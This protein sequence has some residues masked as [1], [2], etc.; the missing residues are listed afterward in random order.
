[1]AMV[2]LRPVEDHGGDG[3]QPGYAEAGAVCE[4]VVLEGAKVSGGLS[5]NR[6]QSEAE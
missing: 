6:K 2:A 4:G 3:N 5:A 1:M